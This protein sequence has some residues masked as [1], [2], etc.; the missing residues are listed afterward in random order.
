MLMRVQSYPDSPHI[1]HRISPL[2]NQKEGQTAPF[3]E[4]TLRTVFP[5]KQ[6]HNFLNGRLRISSVM[7]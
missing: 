5:A 4:L 7:S 6:P 1:L 3:S 2:L